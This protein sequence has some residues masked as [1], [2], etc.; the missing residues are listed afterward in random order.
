MKREDINL[1]LESLKIVLASNITNLFSKTEGEEGAKT[2]KYNKNLEI[3][4]DAIN[5]NDDDTELFLI[6]LKDSISNL[7]PNKE[8]LIKIQNLFNI[9]GE[10]EDKER[11][12]YLFVT[13]FKN[14]LD[15]YIPNEFD[16]KYIC[17]IMDI[18]I[19]D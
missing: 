4:E 3:I 6:A 12:S 17:K 7:T 8:M 11:V 19:E 10:K 2:R 9:T 1:F 5:K 15:S 13:K 16:L 18:T 14:V